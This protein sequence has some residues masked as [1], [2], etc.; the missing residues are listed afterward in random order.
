[1]ESVDNYDSNYQDTRVNVD[2]MTVNDRGSN[3]H[4]NRIRTHLLEL[5]NWQLQIHTSVAHLMCQVVHAIYETDLLTHSR[6]V[7][8]SV[9]D[10]S[11]D[12]RRVRRY[13]P[14][15]V[16]QSSKHMSAHFLVK[17]SWI[18]SW[19]H[20]WQVWGYTLSLLGSVQGQCLTCPVQNTPSVLA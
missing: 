4:L 14:H 10:T 11:E 12:Y 16:S 6:C 8:R 7:P 3:E 9:A 20:S 18:R 13:W 2:P 15:Q 1:M 17:Y 5:R 19:E